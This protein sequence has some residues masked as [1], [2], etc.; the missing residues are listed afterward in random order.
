M[1]KSEI[2]ILRRDAVRI[3]SFGL[4]SSLGFRHWSF[5]LVYLVVCFLIRVIR[6]QL[7]QGWLW[8]DAFASTAKALE[9]K[10]HSIEVKIDHRRGVKGQHLAHDQSAH[11]GNS[12]GSPQF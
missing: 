11:D 2:R 10:P 12:K 5:F 8:G 1:T 3:S 4:L 7:S 9:P 6:G